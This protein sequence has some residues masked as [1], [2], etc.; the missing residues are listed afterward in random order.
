MEIVGILLA[1]EM[2]RLTRIR[3]MSVKAKDGE[4]GCVQVQVSMNIYFAPDQ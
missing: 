2:Q 4:L 1:E 3:N